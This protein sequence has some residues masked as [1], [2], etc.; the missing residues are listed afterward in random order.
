VATAV[1]AAA[2]LSLVAA[3]LAQLPGTFIPLLPALGAEVVHLV[4]AFAAGRFLIRLP[5]AAPKGALDIIV[6]SIALGMALLALLTLG[7]AAADLLRW[8]TPWIVDAIALGIGIT[9]LPEALERLLE[10]VRRREHAVIVGFRVPLF[11][12]LAVAVALHVVPPLVPPSAATG[13]A[14][15]ALA[16]Q[17]G[18]RESLPAALDALPDAAA[19]PSQALV[20]HGH[21]AAGAV[22]ARLHGLALLL[23]LAAAAFIHLERRFGSRA[24]GWGALIL[25]TIPWLFER[26]AR[27]PGAELVLLY[28]FLALREISDWLADGTG[29]KIALAS[30]YGGLLVAES[31][32]GVSVFVVLLATVIVVQVLVE[33]E[34]VLRPLGGVAAMAGVAL[35]TALP[36]IG[37]SV[38][39][40]P[41]ALSS[42]ERRYAPDAIATHAARLTNAAPH[43]SETELIVEMARGVLA[44]G[45]LLLGF[46]LLIPFA[47]Q[48]AAALRHA[49][50]AGALGTLAVLGPPPYGTRLAL[51][52]PAVL[53]AAVAGVAA[54]S[55]RGTAGRIAGAL[56]TL[57][58][59]A[60]LLVVL[61]SGPD[62][63]AGT[64][65]VVG[66]QD[67]ADYLRATLPDAG[68]IA[69]V[70]TRGVPDDRCVLLVGNLTDAHYP[71]PVRRA[72]GGS[73]ALR[74]VLGLDASPTDVAFVAWNPAGASRDELEILGRLPVLGTHAGL[75]LL[76]ARAAAR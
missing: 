9:R 19:T 56:A 63:G 42:L 68:L 58:T 35:L 50:L 20:L 15:L 5:R 3:C 34:G 12:A 73:D 71:L 64:R 7:F 62:L 67:P 40:D 54:M 61:G 26:A 25:L 76:D 14:S 38:A 55:R 1:V 39:L 66:R 16:S 70:A 46:V 17:A 13:A 11:S 23:L 4:A 32:E 51:I 53:A 36:F 33:R 45:P 43:A 24:A 21:L 41:D 2:A 74:A 47:A 10:P 48:D 30:G 8:W 75:L 72:P 59:A 52:A 29:G 65:V 22:G 69:E 28:G 57:A 37:L 6:T 27:D 44:M 18:L 60:S 31:A 49:V